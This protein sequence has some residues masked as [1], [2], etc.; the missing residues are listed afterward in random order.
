MNQTERSKI[1]HHGSRR[2]AEICG[3][4][5]FRIFFP[6]GLFLGL[7]GVSLW[8]LFYFGFTSVYPG[9]THARLMIEGLMASFIFGFLGTAGPRIP[10][11]PHFSPREVGTIL[12]LDLLAAG[13]H[14]GEAHRLGDICF[15][16]CLL[17]FIWGLGRRVRQ[18]KDSPPPNFV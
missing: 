5:P 13:F 6:A 3:E 16:L 4:E 1:N 17:L 14:T 10:S 12:T 2:V 9:I 11:A 15:A 8:P 18:R 7:V